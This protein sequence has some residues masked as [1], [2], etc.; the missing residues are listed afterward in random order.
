MSRQTINAVELDSFT[1]PTHTAIEPCHC[2]VLKEQQG[3]CSL[4]VHGTFWEDCP[5][6]G[7]NTKLLQRQQSATNN[8]INTHQRLEWTERK[9]NEVWREDNDVSLQRTYSHR[10]VSYFNSHY[11]MRA[12]CRG[13]AHGEQLR[14]VKR[15]TERRRA[16]QH[17][18]VQRKDNKNTKESVPMGLY[19]TAGLS[20][21][22]ARVLKSQGVSACYKPFNTTRSLL[23]H[24]TDDL[25]GRGP[26]WHHRRQLHTMTTEPSAFG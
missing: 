3:Y 24:P 17:R 7:T 11:N 23:L 21:H 14:L 20:E 6:T 1:G 9:K 13:P 12:R 4:F 8:E 26:L 25:Q 2:T 10:T 16:T 18:W 22:P 5:D 19:Y 15:S